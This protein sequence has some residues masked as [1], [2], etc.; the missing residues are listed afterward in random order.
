M[1]E[2]AQI[3]RVCN[4]YLGLIGATESDDMHYLAVSLAGPRNAVDRLIGRL[5]LLR[6]LR[7]SGIC[8]SISGNCVTGHE[9]R[10]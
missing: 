9:S 7:Q 1:P 10:R 5:S 2:K 8:T 4:E 3:S 6:R